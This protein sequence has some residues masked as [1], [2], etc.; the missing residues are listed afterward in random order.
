MNG[1]L[2]LASL[3]AIA[4][5]A[6][7]VWRVSP[8]R[9][10]LLGIGC[11][12]GV[13][14]Y[15][16]AF[17]FAG[18]YRRAI[19]DRDM[20]GVTAQIA[21]LALA[22]ALFAPVLAAGEVLGHGVSAALAPVSVSMALGA[23]VFGVGMQIGGGCASG[24]LFTVGGG[25]PRMV[26]VLA[27]FCAGGF[28]ASLHLG[29]WQALP[30]AG[31]ISLGQR[32]GYGRAVTVQLVALGLTYGMLHLAGARNRRAMWWQGGFTARALV[33][34]PWP[35]LLG[36]G[37]LA[38]L[39]FAT[40]ALA[41]HPWTITWGF[42]LWAAKAAVLLG[43]DPST[44]GF[45][46]GAFQRAALERSLLHDTTSV[47][48]LGI[49]LGAALASALAARPVARA[50]LDARGV[51]TAVLGG[52]MLGYGARLA[53]GCNVGAFFSGVASTSL[54]GWVW[55]VCAAIGNVAGVR[56]SRISNRTLG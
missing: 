55:I 49:V 56:L 50:A 24:T 33:R 7:L 14:L 44:S 35:L 9:A 13:T 23:L 10:G 29:W 37:L 2:A 34:G 6:V 25:S 22:M 18:A 19:V 36:A 40:L 39:N 1:P 41:G 12:L 11:A 27:A 43:W 45:W 4:A 5:L 53:Y 30:D 31:A 8:I 51:L 28:W 47:M 52:L 46:T 17:G 16:A 3:V 48:N 42:T 26:V 15:H 21:M 38:A 20:S 54:H 32:L